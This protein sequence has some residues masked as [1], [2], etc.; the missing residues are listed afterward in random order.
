QRVAHLRVRPVGAR[1]RIRR[2]LAQLL[3]VRG[4]VGTRGRALRSPGAASAGA[5]PAEWPLPARQPPQLQPQVLPEVGAPL[6]RLRAAARPAARLARR[7]GGRGV[8]A[9]PAVNLAGAL[10]LALGS[11]VALNWGYVAQHGAAATRRLA[12]DVVRAPPVADGI[13]RRSRRLGPVRRG[14]RA[15]AAVA[16]SGSVSR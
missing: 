7:V 4:A 13:L 16:R 6:P 12:E 9:V 10:A 14:A 5:A 8:P 1:A 2:R 11:S 15:R 3:A